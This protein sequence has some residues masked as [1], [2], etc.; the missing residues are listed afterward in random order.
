MSVSMVAHPH[1][2]QAIPSST[3]EALAQA[4]APLPQPIVLDASEGEGRPLA[5]IVAFIKAG[6][7]WISWGGYPFYYTPSQPGGSSLNFH[8]FCQLANISDPGIAIGQE[9]FVPGFP[10]NQGVRALVTSQSTLPNPWFADPDFPPKSVSN[11]YVWGAIGVPIGQGWW[12]YAST[13][14]GPT[15]AANYARF[16]L[17]LVAPAQAL[18]ASTV[19]TQSPSVSIPTVAMPSHSGAPRWVLWVGGAGLVGLV[20]LAIIWM[21]RR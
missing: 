8:R 15:T 17:N 21:E 12:F 13:D 9:F 10:I 1:G 7:I 2:I 20:T 3:L 4:L 16:I 11:A 19:P 18:P 14:Y 5:D 6:G